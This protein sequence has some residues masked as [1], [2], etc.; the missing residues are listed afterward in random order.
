[1]IRL[2]GGELRIESQLNSVGQSFKNS[3]QHFVKFPTEH[4]KAS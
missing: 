2:T 3:K 1:M 4:Q